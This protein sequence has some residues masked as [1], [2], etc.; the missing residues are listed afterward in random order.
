MFVIMLA[1]LTMLRDGVYR[2]TVAGSSQ[3]SFHLQFPQTADATIQLVMSYLI[4]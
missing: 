4:Y 3:K 2:C 1:W